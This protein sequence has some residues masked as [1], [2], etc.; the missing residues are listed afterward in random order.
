MAQRTFHPITGDALIPY[1]AAEHAL[2]KLIEVFETEGQMSE[3]ECEA[4]VALREAILQDDPE[5]DETFA[6]SW[7]YDPYQNV[8]IYQP[9]VEFVVEFVVRGRFTVTARTKEEAM[10]LAEDE[11]EDRGLHAYDTYDSEAEDVWEK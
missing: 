10:R 6:N 5:D 3:G 11:F 9:E 4:V 8:Y 7:K 1:N 2:Y